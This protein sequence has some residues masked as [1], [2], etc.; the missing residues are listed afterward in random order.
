M[1][2]RVTS[3]PHLRT[4]RTTQRIML[5]VIIALAPAGIA[6]IIFFGWRAAAI[7]ALSVFSAVMWEAIAQKAMKRPV[8]VNDCSAIVTGLLLA[9][10]LPVTVPFWIPIVGSAIAIVLVKQIFGGLGQNFMNPAL[11]ARAILLVSWGGLM[12][13]AAFNVP[14]MGSDAIASATPLAAAAQ[15]ADFPLWNL[16]LGNVPGVI[17]E[18]SKL[19]LL[20]GGIYLMVTKVISW[21]VPV[22]FLGTVFILSW[23]FSGNLMDSTDSALYQLLSGGLFLA[24][25]FMATDYASSPVMPV[26]RLIMGVGCGVLTFIIR[27]YNPAYPEGASYAILIMNL[28]VPLIDRYTKPRLY[29]RR[30]LN[31]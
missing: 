20:I 25:F 27:R 9:Y 3:S 21:R 11:A 26:G 16:F 24:A 15:A 30:K 19:A 23:I 4:K 12:S 14:I 18:T 1:R 17:G 7:I 28:A 6:G 10:N 2:W 22:A 8:T 5:H 13:G 31:A 29:G